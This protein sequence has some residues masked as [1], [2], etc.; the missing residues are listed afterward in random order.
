MKLLI[1]E[2]LF[3]SENGTDMPD[4]TIKGWEDDYHMVMEVSISMDQLESWYQSINKYNG[5]F[6][7]MVYLKS[8]ERYPLLISKKELDA[9]VSKATNIIFN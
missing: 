4:G 1:L 3:L 9:T 8:G 2:A 6:V 5:R 7:T